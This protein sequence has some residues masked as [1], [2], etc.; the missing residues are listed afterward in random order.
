MCFHYFNFNYIVRFKY[1]LIC[2]IL[3]SNCTHF[4][5]SIEDD[6]FISCWSTIFD[7]NA[8]S[9]EITNYKVWYMVH[10]TNKYIYYSFVYFYLLASLCMNA[11]CH[12][13][14][15]NYNTNP[16][17]MC[18]SHQTGIQ[19]AIYRR[20]YMH[21]HMFVKQNDAFAVRA[22]RAVRISFGTGFIILTSRYPKHQ[23]LLS[24][25][26]IYVEFTLWR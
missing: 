21:L 4:F 26:T 17:S 19:K 13:L 22:A 3:F 8:L 9:V 20:L 5:D 1:L 11:I 12:L 14:L 23:S 25:C 18:T 15:I 7:G 2:K 6:T 24:W 16:T 10:S